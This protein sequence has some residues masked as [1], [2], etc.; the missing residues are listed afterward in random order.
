[1]PATTELRT[2]LQKE[3]RRATRGQV[4]GELHTLADQIRFSYETEA[5]S[6]A[7]LDELAVQ[8]RR[9]WDARS[10]LLAG[11]ASERVR[12]DLLDLALLSANLEV[13]RAAA[14]QLPAA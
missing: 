8:C 6:S 3:L 10:R 2:S 14:E 11:D 5:L 13:R 4:V 7:A 9:L 12:T 1:I